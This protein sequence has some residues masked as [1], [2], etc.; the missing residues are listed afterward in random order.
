MDTLNTRKR[1]ILT[2]ALAGLTLL[3]A[4]TTPLRAAHRI[5]RITA[6]TQESQKFESLLS[7]RMAQQAD[8]IES[9]RTPRPVRHLRAWVARLRLPAPLLAPLSVTITSI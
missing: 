7:A 1:I 6:A 2:T 3:I 4:D 5:A 8:P 9:S